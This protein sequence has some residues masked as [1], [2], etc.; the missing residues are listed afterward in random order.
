[1]HADT[2]VVILCG[3]Q[4]TRIREA[5]ESLPKAMVEIG[6][7]P[8]VWHI[9]KLYREAGFRRFVLCLGYK[10]WAIKEYFLD[11]RARVADFTLNMSDKHSIDF[12]DGDGST[13]EDWQITFAETGLET[14]T[15]ARVRRILPYVDTEN[16]LL[17]YGD[18][19][20]DIDIAALTKEHETSGKV[21]T[22][23]GVHPTS[24]FGEMQVDADR[25]VEFNEKPTQVTGFVSGGFF[26]FRREFLTDYLDDD[27]QLWLE[28]TP[29][30]RLARDGQLNVHRHDG[31]WSA[32]DTYKDFTYLNELWSTGEAPWKLW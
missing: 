6:G 21:G 18:G 9:M 15:G 27:P 28:H 12:H 29:L 32:M 20:S 5:S 30:Q 25:V 22:V 13:G 11:Y 7:R 10:S 16:F 26:A 3:G 19:V 24:K 1:M 4:G 31:F 2:P 8:I 23:T 14:A 17:T